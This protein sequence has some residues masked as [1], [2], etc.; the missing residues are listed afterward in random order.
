[1]GKSAPK[2]TDPKETSAAQTGTSVST[3]IANGVMN[4]VNQRDAGRLKQARAFTQESELLPI[5]QPVLDEN[6]N[7]VQNPGY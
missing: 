3:A 7:L 5:P 4:N 2:P 6:T 1:M